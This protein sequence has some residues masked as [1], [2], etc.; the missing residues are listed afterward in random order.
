MDNT[1]YEIVVKRIVLR[2]TLFCILFFFSTD[3]NSST[4]AHS[5]LI[6][7]ESCFK[8]CSSTVIFQPF[9]NFMQNIDIL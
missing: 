9:G 3:I 1:Y 4:A 8:Y 6:Q 2:L 7:R 5:S